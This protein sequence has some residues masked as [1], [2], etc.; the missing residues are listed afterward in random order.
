MLL[1]LFFF[2]FVFLFFFCLFFFLFVFFFGGGVSLFVWGGRG[3]K[4][5][6]FLCLID[7]FTYE[8]LTYIAKGSYY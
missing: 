6:F 1:L 3:A 2:C 4:G 5:V 7:F 8:R